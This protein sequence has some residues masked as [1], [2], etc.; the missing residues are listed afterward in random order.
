LKIAIITGDFP[1]VISGVGDYSYHL[2]EKLVFKGEKIYVITT[3]N[4][5]IIPYPNSLKI[6][7]NLVG[8]FKLYRYLKRAQIDMINLQYPC[9]LYGKY[10]LM[11]HIYILLFHL[12]GFKIITTLHEFSNVNILRRLSEIIFIL[13]SN[14]IVVTNK[15]DHD[16]IVAN[17]RYIIKDKIHIIPIGSNIDSSRDTPVTHQSPYIVFFGIFYPNKQTEKVIEIMS[18]IQKKFKDQFIFRFVGGIHPY[19]EDYVSGFRKK[20]EEQLKKTEWYLN[21]PLNRI[22]E[23]LKDAFA[24]VLYFQ[25]GASIRRGSLLAMLANGIPVLTKKGI[26]YQDLLEIED[27]GLFY[28]SEDLS[29]LEKIITAL[30]KENFYKEC[31]LKLKNFAQKF[32]F[33]QIAKEYLKVFY[34][35]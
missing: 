9:S 23:L 26:Y 33:N 32:S 7:W 16:V 2:T 10:N 14:K 21:Y 11:P 17:F 18:E 29:N 4:P 30:Q 28:L 22:P 15:Y 20:A 3:L 19:Y 35:V 1:S 13:S 8:F 6:K 24:S 34:S 31:F 27:K 5:Q 12:L 25:D